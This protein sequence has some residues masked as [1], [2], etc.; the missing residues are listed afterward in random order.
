MSY[1]FSTRNTRVLTALALATALTALPAAAAIRSAR[2]RSAA[3]AASAGILQEALAW[4]SALWGGG[5]RTAVSPD[6]GGGVDPNGTRKTL[7]TIHPP[8]AAP[9]GGHRRG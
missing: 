8:A 3:P 4:L 7:V 5:E 2:P 9:S 6:S 1:T